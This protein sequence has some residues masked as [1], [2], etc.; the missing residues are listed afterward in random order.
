MVAPSR[1]AGTRPH[2]SLHV[3][4]PAVTRHHRS[5]SLYESFVRPLAFTLG[6]E[7]AHNLAM[8]LIC[9]GLVRTR[10]FG[11]PRLRQTL[12]GVDFPNPLGLAAGFDKN[13]VAIARWQDLGFGF[14]ELG[15]IT[16][17]AQPGNPQPR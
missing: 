4:R 3:P 13:A 10:T 8:G 14:A 16:R 11:D 2:R 12:F 15:T 6:A 7:K 5:V 17:H 1:S 9:K